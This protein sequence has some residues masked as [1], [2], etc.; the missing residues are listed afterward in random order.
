MVL[1]NFDGPAPPVNRAGDGYPTAED[2]EFS[3]KFT[4][5][6]EP[7]DAVA[8]GSLRMRLT[9][10]RL[11]A[12][13]TPEEPKGRKTFTRDYSANPA[14]WRFNTYNRWRFWIKT[15]VDAAAHST[16]GNTN[17]SVGTYARRVKDTDES[18]L[19]TGGGAYF[20]RFNVPALGCWTQVVVNMHL[21]VANDGSEK[22][23]GSLPHPT[24]EPDYNYFD[25]L[26]RFYIEARQPPAKYPAD[27][28]LDE[29]EFYQESQKENDD[30]VYGITATHVP[31][32]NRVIVTW[33][34]RVG[35]DTM[36]HEVRYSF[37]DV[38]NTGWVNARFGEIVIPPGK[39]G[40]NGMVFDARLPLTGQ[41]MVYIA[42]KPQNSERFSQIAVPLT[43][44]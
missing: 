34:R 29:I 22:D 40:A 41:R 16:T 36:A 2:G 37:S 3:G 42:I 10:G 28:L 32:E 25:A 38:H 7:A 26:T 35:E 1:V 39:G 31:G 43:L 4:T 17:M 21:H 33:N 5:S 9:A 27:Y 15:P 30:Q 12:Q 23:L 14:A 44:K 13:F 20:H 24:G 8:G 19:S 11:K 18:S 6:I